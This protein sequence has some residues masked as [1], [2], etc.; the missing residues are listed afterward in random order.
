M[1]V[2]NFARALAAKA[3]AGGGA[4]AV[5][6]EDF[7]DV[8]LVKWDATKK[9]FV[10]AGETIDGIKEYVNDKSAESITT[11]LNAPV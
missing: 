8:H 4:G 5:T 7:T 11:V 1:A 2:D 9:S 6:P 3:I 10:D